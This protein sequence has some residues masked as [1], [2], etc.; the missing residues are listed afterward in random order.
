MCSSGPALP[1]SSE[2]SSPSVADL[3]DVMAGASTS[4]IVGL[5]MCVC[6]PRGLPL[7]NRL[8]LLVWLCCCV[9]VCLPSL[10]AVAYLVWYGELWL[11]CGGREYREWHKRSMSFLRKQTSPSG[12]STGP[13]YGQISAHHA[14]ACRVEGP[15]NNNWWLDSHAQHP[16]I[17][18]RHLLP[19]TSMCLSK[20]LFSVHISKP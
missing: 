4:W 3:R 2:R 8:W 11:W 10:W 18:C 6:L 1:R 9:V 12:F 13:N 17:L 16:M 19:K 14:F 15:L 20:L 5:A 7:W